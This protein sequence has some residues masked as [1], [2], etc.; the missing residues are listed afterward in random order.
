MGYNKF[1]PLLL[2]IG[3]WDAKPKCDKRVHLGMELAEMRRF[4]DHGVLYDLI[5]NPDKHAD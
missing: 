2:K 5:K 1:K 3:A 4:G